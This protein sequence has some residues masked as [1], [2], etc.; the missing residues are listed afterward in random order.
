MRPPSV[1]RAVNEFGTA[2]VDGDILNI[3]RAIDNAPSENI[4]EAG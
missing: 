3:S 1:C 2:V 4:V